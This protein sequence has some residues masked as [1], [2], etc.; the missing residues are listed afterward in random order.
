VLAGGLGTRMRPATEAIPK[1]LIPVLGRPFA[2]W[3]LEHLAA[4]GIERV[5]YSVG[6]RGDMLRAHIGDGSRVGL[7]IT[8]VDE[9]EH[10]RG[11]GGA[12][13]L[14]LDEGALDDVFFVVFGDSYLPIAMDDVEAAWRDSNQPALMTVLRNEG[15]LDSSNVIYKDGRVVL[16]DKSRPQDKQSEMHW[17]DYGL[18]VL[19]R[20]MIATRIASGTVADLADVMKDLSIEGRLAGLEA[21]Q[22]FYE[23]GSP[24]GLLDLETYLSEKARSGGDQ[25]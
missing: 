19:T 16:Y 1:A 13:R 12:L 4:Q 22:R 23:A 15:R 18:S 5:T 20:D 8:W 10:L 14:A 25:R 21:K 2:D 17:I 6:Y 11:T 9:G 7:N 3:Q 24:S